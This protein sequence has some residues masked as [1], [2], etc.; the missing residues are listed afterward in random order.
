[1]NIL[2]PDN[3]YIFHGQSQA[4]HDQVS[5]SPIQTVGIIRR[6]LAFI[7]S[8]PLHDLVF[9]LTRAVGPSKNDA[10]VFPVIVFFDFFLDEKV[11]HFVKFL[12]E[13]GTWRDWVVFEVLLTV[14]A[15]VVAVESFD[16]LFVVPCAF[17]PTWALIVHFGS[18]GDT[19]QSE[20]DHFIGFQ[21]VDDHI[22]VV[23]DFDPDFLKLFGHNL[24]L[25]DDRV[26]LD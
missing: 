13:L 8:D 18:R 1:M 7:C 14:S 22:N 11:Y 9:T 19:V 2:L 20:E 4:Q 23:E 17:E 26:V 25:E 6:E 24:G 21:N 16:K 10:D 12:H 5:I 3:A 15:F